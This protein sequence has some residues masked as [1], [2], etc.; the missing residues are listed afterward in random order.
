MDINFCFRKINNK[1]FIEVINEQITSR[2][3]RI[4]DPNFILQQDNANTHRAKVVK[5]YF[6]EKNIQAF[7]R[8]AYSPPTWT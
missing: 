8:P 7:E 6:T 3:M 5:N 4:A 2:A 1:R